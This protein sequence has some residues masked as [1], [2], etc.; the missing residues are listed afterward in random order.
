MS[1]AGKKTE[2]EGLT[3]TWRI[4]GCSLYTAVQRRF[5]FALPPTRRLRRYVTGGVG[6]FSV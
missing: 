3:G 6:Y 1:K 2:E 4:W 5:I